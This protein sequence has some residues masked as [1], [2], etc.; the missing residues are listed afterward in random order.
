MQAGPG[1]QEAALRQALAADPL[2]VAALIGYAGMFI[3]HRRFD[4]ARTLARQAAIAAPG[5]VEPWAYLSA[6]DAA[7]GR[8]HAGRLAAWRMSRLDPLDAAVQ[9]R[10]AAELFHRGDRRGSEEALRRAL[11]LDPAHAQALALRAFICLR[12]GEY[13]R[14]FRYFAER[15]RIPALAGL[16]RSLPRP[17]WTGD[18]PAG[19]TIVVISEQGHGDTLM[20][21]RYLALLKSRGA[22]VVL[23]AAPELER[24]LRTVPFIDEVV[25]R[26]APLPPFDGACLLF[27]LPV[28]LGLGDEVPAEVPVAA[29]PAAIARWRARL[30]P[31]R[32]NVGLA[33]SGNAANANDYLRSLPLAALR[34]LLDL[35]GVAWHSLQ[36]DGRGDDIAAVT[37][38]RIADH[39]AGVADF[40]DSAAL[41][42]ALD[43][44][45]TV[46]SAPAH[47][48]G[49]LGRPVWVMLYEPTDWRWGETSEQSAWYASATLFRQQVAGRWDDVVAAV[50]A[51][52]AQS[53]P[54]IKGNRNHG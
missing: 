52:L 32:V 23:V 36:V 30:D 44:V 11:I 51:R 5:E 42:A 40:A 41:T 46:D 4:V 20:C 2:N 18:D 10:A 9:Y 13:R 29:D 48:A 38:G 34:P 24:L 7:A 50:A 8:R 43:L 47:L 15:W 19:R 3:G 31:A 25:V 12:R 49:V 16:E 33:W 54:T 14:G 1:Q 28:L 45:I 6:I 37:P 39:R 17:Y 27:T 35:P 26:G 21:L 53:L 22:R